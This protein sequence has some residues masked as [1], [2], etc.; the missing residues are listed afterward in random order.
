MATTNPALNTGVRAVRACRRR[1]R[2]SDLTQM[3]P[4]AATAMRDNESGK[5]AFN[6]KTYVEVGKADPDR[7]VSKDLA[8]SRIH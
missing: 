4:Q 5:L 3:R 2:A 1:G 7:Q 6:F 8:L